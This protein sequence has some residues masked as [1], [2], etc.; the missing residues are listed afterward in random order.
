M[1]SGPA[2]P[3]TG[4]RSELL[5]QVPWRGAVAV[6]AGS[7]IHPSPMVDSHT[8][9]AVAP[10]TGMHSLQQSS[11]VGSH[12]ERADRQ[13][14]VHRS[15]RFASGPVV[16]PPALHNPVQH[17]A[18]AVQPWF[19]GVQGPVRAQNPPLQSPVQH[20]PSPVQGWPNPVH[21][22]GTQVP[23][24]VQICPAGHEP[25]V[26]SGGLQPTGAA[27]KQGLAPVQRPLRAHGLRRRIFLTLSLSTFLLWPL[28]DVVDQ[29]QIR[30][31]SSLFLL[32]FLAPASWR[33]KPSPA[34]AA[35]AAS[36][37]RAL[38]RVSRV[39]ARR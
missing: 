8:V 16:V 5:P 33:A 9:V 6:A 26:L 31:L 30:R 38:P 22:A 25:R 1:P 7:A 20:C 29:M 3:A 35:L 28:A 32:F 12:V 10:G 34:R 14:V 4:Q 23:L 18:L 21:P 19:A 15:A 39:V 17:W 11:K 2:L 36:P 24:V 13:A 27:P 37:R